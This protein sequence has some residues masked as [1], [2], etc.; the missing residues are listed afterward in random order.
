M[1]AR[2][3]IQRQYLSLFDAPDYNA[4]R[5]NEFK[6]DVIHGYGSYLDALFG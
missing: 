1:P 5:L 2:V 6:P 4:R 3:P